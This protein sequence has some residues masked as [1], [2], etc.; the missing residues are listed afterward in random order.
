MSEKKKILIVDD[1]K[2]LLD[3]YATKFSEH[4]F[5]VDTA[6]NGGDVIE[7]LASGENHP[8]IM[9]LDIVMPGTDGFGVLQELKDKKLINGMTVIILSNLGQ[10]EDIDKGLTLGAHGYI[11]KAS[12]TPSEVVVRVSEIIKNN[13]NK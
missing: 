12:A 1:D 3:M 7:K 11:V 10:Q 5:E 2:F 13:N 4:A 9:L 6:M 8:D